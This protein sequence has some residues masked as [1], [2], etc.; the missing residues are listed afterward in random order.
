[1]ALV[2]GLASVGVVIV[3]ALIVGLMIMLGQEDEG[4]VAQGPAGGPQWQVLDPAPNPWG[5]P[6]PPV[7]IVQRG[8]FQT[9][10]KIVPLDLAGKINWARDEAIDLGGNHLGDL[11]IGE[12]TFAGVRFKIQHGALL[13]GGRPDPPTGKPLEIGGIKAPAKFQ[14]L[15][16]FHGAHYSIFGPKEIGGYRLRYDDG[17]STVLAIVYGSDVTDW[18][19]SFNPPADRSRLGWSGRNGASAISFYVTRYDNPHPEKTVV[20]VDVFATN[21]GAAPVCIALTVEEN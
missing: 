10:G 3:V 6:E 16:A 14:R 12:Q 7:P 18:F 9:Q 21:V 15:Y 1:M 17:Q 5:D 2:V 4:F 19:F 8:P 11:P 13:L 20:G